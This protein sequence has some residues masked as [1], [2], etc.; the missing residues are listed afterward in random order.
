TSA[1]RA[2]AQEHGFTL[3]TLVQGAWALLL[4]LY[5]GEED[6]IFGTTRACRHSSLS[7]IETMVGLFINT[8]PF[9][10]HVPRNMPLLK[11]LKGVRAQHISLREFEHTP[12]IKI[13]EWSDIARGMA[14]FDSILVFEN[15]SLN[16][17]LRAQGGDWERR[18]FQAL[19]QTNYPL[20][21]F[22]YA[23]TEM[24]LK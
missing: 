19:E 5:T 16:S 15:S 4:S 8:I 6:V 9:K 12:L 7:G 23:E 10:A 1:L 20:T 22:G 11:W 24:L 17:D 2:L 13:Q 21:V 3:N 14:L 18:E